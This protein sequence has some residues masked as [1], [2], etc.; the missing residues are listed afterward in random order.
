MLCVA[1]EVGGPAAVLAEAMPKKTAAVRT[2]VPIRFMESFLSRDS[3]SI[4][5]D[6]SRANQPLF[7]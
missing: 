1:E 3:A 7:M 5:H 6:P 4:T 2:Q